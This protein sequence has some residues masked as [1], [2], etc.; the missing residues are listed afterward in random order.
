MKLS[1]TSIIKE[2]NLREIYEKQPHDK[3]HEMYN[4]VS[5]KP[6][7]TLF[8]FANTKQKKNSLTNQQNRSKKLF[9]KIFV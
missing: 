6:N 1:E 7:S 2:T 5:N 8:L 9:D 4:V 3:F